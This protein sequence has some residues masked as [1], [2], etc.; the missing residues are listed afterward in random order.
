MSQEE[1][2]EEG[3]QAFYSLAGQDGEID[4]FELQDILN[5]VFQQDFKFEGFTTDLT[6]S[7]VAMRD[8]DMSG[9]LGF[10]DF[11][12]LWSDLATC[13]KAFIA[14]DIDKSGYFNRSEFHKGLGSIGV[15]ISEN[16]LRALVMRYSDKDGN[17]R[18][19]D[20]VGCF[21]K[22]KTMTKTFRDKDVYNQGVADFDRDEYVQLGMYC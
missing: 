12:K 3:R 17:I 5:K 19:N 1:L 9:K 4:A 18:F 22:L 6:R 13:K 2:T 16:V 11:K 21:I 8:Y 10:E 7:M 20:F 15:T 14:L